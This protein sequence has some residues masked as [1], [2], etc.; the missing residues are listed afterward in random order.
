MREHRGSK[1]CSFCWCNRDVV[2][3]CLADEVHVQSIH[4]LCAE[5]VSSSSPPHRGGK[6]ACVNCCLACMYYESRGTVVVCLIVWALANSVKWGHLLCWHSTLDLLEK[7]FTQHSVNILS[8]VHWLPQYQHC[9]QSNIQNFKNQG[10]CDVFLTCMNRDVLLL[11][12][13]TDWQPNMSNYYCRWWTNSPF[14]CAWGGQ[15]LLSIFVPGT[16]TLSIGW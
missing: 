10:L 8:R 9:A 5:L 13:L 2:W 6:K 12:S 14:I 4:C 11:W 15:S 3:G 16:H 7:S 1:D